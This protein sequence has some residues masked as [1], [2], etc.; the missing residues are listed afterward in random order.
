VLIF[1]YELGLLLTTNGTSD[2]LVHQCPGPFLTTFGTIAQWSFFDFSGAGE[3]QRQQPKG[4]QLYAHAY[5]CVSVNNVS[6]NNSIKPSNSKNRENVLLTWREMSLRTQQKK[7][8]K[9]R[10]V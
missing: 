8:E 9:A 10:L 7:E 6:V 1:G 3:H 5:V 4:Q 2:F